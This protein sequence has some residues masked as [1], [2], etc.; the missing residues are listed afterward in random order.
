MPAKSSSAPTVEFSYRGKHVQL[1]ESGDKA[2]IVV[3]QKSFSASRVSGMWV[4]EGVHNPYRDLSALARHI[5][6][7]LHLF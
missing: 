4:A 1:S 6:D 3:D 2:T 7:Y 5:V